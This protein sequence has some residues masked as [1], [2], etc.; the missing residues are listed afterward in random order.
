MR[1]ALAWVA[2]GARTHTAWAWLTGSRVTQFGKTPLHRVAQYGEEIAIKALVAAKA[3][4]NAKNKVRVGEE[5]RC[6]EGK[7]GARPGFCIFRLWFGG[8]N[9]SLLRDPIREPQIQP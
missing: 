5:G 3:D 4:V 2:G 6:L 9:L 1:G 7:E 8:L